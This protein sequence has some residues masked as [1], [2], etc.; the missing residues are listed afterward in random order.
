MARRRKGRLIDG[1]LLLNKPK[2]GSSNH[3]L[4]RVKRLYFAQKAGHTGNLDPMA[5]GVLPICLGEA[6]KF[7]QYLLDADK[8][9]RATIKLGE[10]TDTGDAE[11]KVI[12]ESDA[13]TVEEKDFLR[14]MEKFRGEIEQIPPM[15][16]ALKVNGRPLYKLA[17]EGIEIER[18]ARKVTIFEFDLLAFRGGRLPEVDVFVHCS[19]GTYIRTLAMDV[20]DSL[21][22]GGHLIALHR[23]KAGQFDEADC[24]GFD[25]L[26][27]LKPSESFSGLDNQLIPAEQAVNHLPLVEVDETSGYYVRLGQAVF[28]PN[29]PIDGL[30]RIR[31]E[32]GTFLGVGEIL[33]DGRVTPKRL[34]ASSA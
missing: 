10:L 9:Y 14:A 6:T 5:T 3:A 22:V 12:A 25:A 21:G 26:E 17:R 15:Y 24:L 13:S 8:G 20:A 27:A 34:I 19:K 11:G 28:V 32:D 23:T 7:S 31:Q 18:K 29:A 30:V 4:Q 1:I 33:D 2:G 16:S